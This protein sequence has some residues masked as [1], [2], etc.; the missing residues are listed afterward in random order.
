M[1]RGFFTKLLCTG[2]LLAGCNSYEGL[3]PEA[4]SATAFPD[5]A[6]TK[7][8]NFEKDISLATRACVA[9]ETSGPASLASLRDDGFVLYSELFIK[10]YMKAESKEGKGLFDRMSALRV[11]KANTKVSCSIEVLRHQSYAAMALISQELERLGYKRH[12][13]GNKVRYIGHGRRFGLLGTYSHY[14]AWAVL[15]LDQMSPE[16][17]RLCRDTSLS[18]AIRESCS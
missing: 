4:D 9:S 2:L 10:G 8:Y 7:S 1:G 14:S 3:P 16:E 18:S 15:E 5:A 6:F 11:H 17:D 12:E 13:S